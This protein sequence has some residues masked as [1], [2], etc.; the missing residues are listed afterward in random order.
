MRYPPAALKR[1]GG[2][3]LGPAYSGKTTAAAVIGTA[4]PGAFS[5]PILPH[6]ALSCPVVPYRTLS[7][8]VLLRYPPLLA[9]AWMGR[10]QPIRCCPSYCPVLYSV[11]THRA[12]ACSRP[13]VKSCYV[14]CS[15]DTT[16]SITI[17]C[18]ALS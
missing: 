12:P 7:C 16:T 3:K 15:L 6:P 9:C 4:P 5:H 14:R 17:H 8:P 10:P 13:G 11:H 2:G 18:P 1:G